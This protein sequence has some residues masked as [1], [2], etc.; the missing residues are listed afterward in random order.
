MKFC[1][2]VKSNYNTIELVYDSAGNTLTGAGV[3]PRDIMEEEKNG[4]LRINVV[5]GTDCNYCCD[6]CCQNGMKNAAFVPSR[7]ETFIEGVRDY[8]DRYFGEVDSANILFWGGEPLIYFDM[9][10]EL[11]A[12]LKDVK[13]NTS[14]GI[15]TNGA[16]LNERNLAWL[17]DNGM[18]VGFSYD[19]PGQ[20]ARNKDDVL[21]PGSFALEALKDGIVNHRWSVNPVFHKGNPLVSRFVAFMNERLG[22]EK[23]GLG[24]IQMLMVGDEASEKWALSE[25]ELYAFSVDC[26]QEIFSGRGQN[27]TQVYFDIAKNFLR[28][29]GKGNS[30]GGCLNSQP[31]GPSLNVDI[32]GNIWVCHSFAGQYVDEMGGNLH[33]GTLDGTRKSV[34]LAVLE[35]RRE[36]ACK[37]CA[38]RMFCGGGCLGT[39]MKYDD[40]N[41]RIQWHKWF[42]ALSMAVN[43]LTGGQLLRIEKLED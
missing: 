23:W 3:P 13:S 30:F 19:G 39:P 14:M 15:C 26:C 43:L 33:I 37:D 31:D 4:G 21:A 2:F 32:T 11:A 22:T 27:F 36:R 20:Y 38:L 8:C 16:L 12:G 29:L 6:Y 28:N 34:K 5:M 25:E 40:M 35:N 10:K 41:C 24:D 18:G 17:H 7:M 42:P 9:M 1:F